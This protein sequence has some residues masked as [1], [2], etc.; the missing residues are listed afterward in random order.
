MFQHEK[1]LYCETN[2]I[3]KLVKDRRQ[4]NIYGSAG[5]VKKL[6]FETGE[7]AGDESFRLQGLKILM[8]AKLPREMFEALNLN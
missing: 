1:L 3:E 2:I 8:W 5:K 7:V 4:R 6:S